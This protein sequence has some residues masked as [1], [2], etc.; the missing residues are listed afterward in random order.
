MRYLIDTNIIVLYLRNDYASKYI[1]E[2]YNPLG[3]ENI[4]VISVVT[5]GELKSLG[6]RNNW[7]PKRQEKLE[8]FLHQF[9]IADINSKDVLDKY[10]EIDA[11]SQD[12]LPGSPLGNSSRNMGKNDL[13][14]ASTAA[15]I[16][17]SLI[18][19]DNDFDHLDNKYLKLIRIDRKSLKDQYNS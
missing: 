8:E 12:K 7:G 5:I 19:T 16:K 4:P 14:I 3:L 13:W 9:L 1:D 17:A 2:K 18:T 15:V 6:I 10:A 11:F